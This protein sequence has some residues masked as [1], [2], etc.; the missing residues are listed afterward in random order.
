M[1]TFPTLFSKR[2]RGTTCPTFW[3]QRTSSFSGGTWIN[4]VYYGN[5]YWVACADGRSAGDE[6]L[7]TSTDGISWT[8]RTSGFGADIIRGGCY[9]DGVYINVGSAGKLFTTTD[10]T[11]SWTSRTSQFGA[12][13]IY[14]VSWDGTYYVAFGEFGKTSTSTDGTTWTAESAIAQSVIYAAEYGNSIWVCGGYKTGGGETTVY[15]ATDPTSTFTKRVVQAGDEGVIYGVAY[16]NSVWVVVGEDASGD[17]II[18]SASNPTSTWT[19]RTTTGF[20]TGEIIFEV[21]FGNECFCAVGEAGTMATSTDGITWIS[22]TSSFSGTNMYGVAYDG[23]S[24]WVATGSSDKIA[25]S[26]V[27]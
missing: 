16:G 23:T 8:Q 7:A 19:S 15:T 3:T 5:G 17:P 20:G 9:A 13:P 26:D 6:S 22:R 4:W 12:D 1:I 18:Y 21:S 2:R 11:T 10:P 25:T 24:R 14:D 27:I